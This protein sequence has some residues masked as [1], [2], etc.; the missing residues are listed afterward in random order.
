[1]QVTSLK[2]RGPWE[3]RKG[4]K[5]FPQSLP[6]YYAGNIVV[7]VYARWWHARVAPGW[8]AFAD[9]M[10]PNR[11]VGVF[12]ADDIGRAALVTYE[13]IETTSHVELIEP[14]TDEDVLSRI[15]H[16]RFGRVPG[17]NAG[18]CAIIDS[19]DCAKRAVACNYDY[20]KGIDPE[21]SRYTPPLSE[22]YWRPRH[23]A[24][25]ELLRTQHG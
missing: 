4:W 23:R 25:M 24:E 7:F 19:M 10:E 8:L 6:D 22:P 21:W 14:V 2:L 5:V 3:L 20:T 11:H 9:W 12:R 16:V 17:W 18:R 13:P 1:M 15:A